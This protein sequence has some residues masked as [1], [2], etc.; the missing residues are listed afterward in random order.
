[1]K[2]KFKSRFVSESASEK[3][4]RTAVVSVVLLTGCTQM[5]SKRNKTLRALDEESRALTTAVVD[6]L[7]SEPTEQRD[8]FS[9]TA[10]A[11]AKQDQRVEGLPVKSFDVPGLM[12][13]L[14]AT[15]A[16]GSAGLS[17]G[18]RGLAS[19]EPGAPRREV[20]E[21]FEEQDRLIGSLAKEE[22]KLIDL[23]V[24][25]EAAR[26]EKITRWTKLSLGTFT[27]FGGAIAV[28]VFFPVAISVAGRFLGWL[29]SKLPGLASACGVVSVKAF[30]AVVR[31]I[32]KTKQESSPAAPTVPVA[33][34]LLT[35][36]NSRRGPAEDFI[37][38]LQNQLSREMDA[39]HKALVRSRKTKLA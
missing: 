16:V 36:G 5:A 18:E 19:A 4:R 21:R 25:A 2:M 8:V 24:K 34:S 17:A 9:L 27:F 1:M 32:E 10:L 14:G 29:V 26:N 3:L 11:F 28:F 7:Q 23:G 35:Q 15:N 31:A 37:N 39:A 22:A 33:N 12:T 38:K 13:D 6:V 30:D 20:L